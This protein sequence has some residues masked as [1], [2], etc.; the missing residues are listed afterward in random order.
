LG[1]ALRKYSFYYAFNKLNKYVYLLFFILFPTLNILAQPDSVDI[2]DLDLYQLTKIK[3]TSA[4][5]VIE[6]KNEVP[7]TVHIITAEEIKENGFLTLEEALSTLPG[8]QFRNIQGINSYIFQRG[9]PNQNNLTLVLIDGIQIN[10]LNSGGFYGGGQYNLTNVDRIEVMY[11]PSSVAYGTNAVSGIINIIT[12]TALKNRSRANLLLGTHNTAKA[13]LNYSYTNESKNFGILFSG[14]LKKSDKADLKSAEGDYNWSDKIDNFEKDYTFD[15]KIQYN[16]LTFGTNFLQKETSTATLNKTVGTIFKDYGTS[17]NIRFVNN[18]LKYQHEFSKEINISSVIY[19]RN[20]TVLDNTIYFVT[21]TAQIGYYRPNNLTGFETII[22]YKP[23][24]IFSISGG[25]TYEYEKLSKYASLSYSNSQFTEPPT[26]KTPPKANNTLV[27][28]FLEPRFVLIDSLFISGGFRYDNSTI[29]NQVFTPR[30]G[31]S[32]NFNKNIAR[33]TYGEAFR[34]PKPWD[35]SDGL[36]NS[37]LVPEKMKSLEAGIS[38]YLSPNY[39]IDITG[40]L[41]KLEKAI[42]KEIYTNGYRWVNSGEV[43]TKGAEIIINYVSKYFKSEINYTYT[44]SDF[45]NNII[46]PE[47]SEH[48]ANFNITYLINNYFKLNLRAD[49]AGERNSPNLIATTN[50]YKISP[51]LIFHGTVSVINYN[52]FDIQLIVKNI[53]DT[54]YYHT[55]N[56][57]V[58]RYRQSQRTIMLSIGYAYN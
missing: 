18:Y 54:E 33:I 37:Y 48:T 55:S 2:Y 17:W 49:F 43:N 22:N 40:Y 31:L 35:Y 46:V 4:S 47:I 24:K 21:D 36:G 7:S 1:V 44:K 11:G 19:N 50:S 13:E 9:I 42:T 20:T 53:F 5:K 10:E 52:G 56:R 41:N 14:M 39:K 28:M 25:L 32:Y 57:D 45:A 30:V 12:K 58:S 23:Y 16:S 15:F 38:L 29:Y 8:F 34:A 51:Y 3:I 26:P 6:N 27:S